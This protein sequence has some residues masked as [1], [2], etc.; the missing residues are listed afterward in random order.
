MNSELD[1]MIEY[2]LKLEKLKDLFN[3]MQKDCN[4]FIKYGDCKKCSVNCVMK[5]V[6]RIME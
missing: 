5:E 4:Y 1:K 6:I 2:G 3:D